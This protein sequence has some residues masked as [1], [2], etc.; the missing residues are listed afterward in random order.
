MTR[1]AVYDEGLKVWVN[2]ELVALIKPS[3]FKYL[4]KDLAEHLAWQ[5]TEKTK[6]Q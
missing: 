2:G 4:L 1:W 5:E 6:K 3:E